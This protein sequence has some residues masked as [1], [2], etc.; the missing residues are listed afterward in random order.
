MVVEEGVIV[1]QQAVVVLVPGGG[2]PELV[3]DHVG[4]DQR[5]VGD[6]GSPGPGPPPALL[7]VR[8]AGAV[9]IRWGSYLTPG[10]SHWVEKHNYSLMLSAYSEDVILFMCCSLNCIFCC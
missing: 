3:S 2:A 7:R 9:Q 5:G 10:I 1:A 8:L 4:G 6:V